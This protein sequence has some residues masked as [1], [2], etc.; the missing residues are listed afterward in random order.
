MSAEKLVLV[1]NCGSSSIKFA[2]VDPVNGE[3]NFNGLVECIGSKD[4]RINWKINGNKET[5][6]LP[7]VEYQEAV[8]KI[9]TILDT[10]EGLSKKIVAVG[11][12]VVHGGE[13]FTQSAL[14]T[15]EV[16]D[17]IQAVSP[18]AP[19]HNPANI[20]GILGAQKAF[21][22]LPHVAVFDTAF[23]Q[24]MP[25]HAFLYAIP[26][27]LY[28]E[29]GVRRYGFHGT[30][31]LFVS[32]E[33]ARLLNKSTDNFACVTCHLGNG[34]SAAA[35]LNGKSVDTTMGL[36]PLEG[37]MMGTR[38]G[39]VDPSLHGFL[40][41]ALGKDVHA[42]T[43]LLNK[44]SGL[45]GLSELSSDM[46]TIE[47]AAM[48]GDEAA[49]RAENV[50]AYRLAKYILALTVPLGRLDALVFTGGIGENGPRIR[51]IVLGM[52][53]ILDFKVD[54]AKNEAAFRGKSGIITT[55]DSPIAIVVPTN[56]E[57]VIAQDAIK[58]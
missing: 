51:K 26:Y 16:L 19:L 34:C 4:S 9:I 56:E 25:E 48:N 10:I 24:T 39:D 28:Q 20:T 12:R 35:V 31:H 27:A 36:T 58:M 38:S 49:I 2:V 1:L 44:K 46:R 43:N 29:H 52:L 42:T 5:R 11:H 47:E 55:N 50:F 7:N 23:H 32:R 8:C 53:G 33:A 57:W 40:A 37:L 41:D 6:P 54:D 21:P 3:T 17:A 22:N 18:L 15:D 30:S 13:K 45:L 14:I